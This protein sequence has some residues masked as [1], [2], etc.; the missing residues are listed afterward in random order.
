MSDIL[1]TRIHLED[2]KVK[3]GERVDLAMK[4]FEAWARTHEL[5]KADPRLRF[6]V[7]YQRGTWVSVDIPAASFVGAFPVIQAGLKSVHV[8]VG[9]LN[10]QAPKLNKISIDGLDED[11]ETVKVPDLEL[12]EGPG[13]ENLS[14]IC[15]QVIVD[16]TTGTIKTDDK[17]KL[18][19]TIVHE[20]QLNES[21]FDGGSPDE[22][23]R[24]LLALAQVVWRDEQIFKIQQIVYQNKEHRWIR[25]GAG[26]RGRHFFPSV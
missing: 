6:T 1:S 13:E 24:G 25:P 9:Y 19:I 17:K 21:H 3:P 18:D 20:I 2:L 23:G 7:S 4:R 26:K 5:I 12:T 11:G 15:L 22:N 16:P 14:W 10:G 8:G